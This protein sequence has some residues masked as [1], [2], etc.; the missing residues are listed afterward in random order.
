VRALLAL[1][2][3]GDVRPTAGRIAERAG[4]SLR[5]VY[6]HFDDLDD[7]FL[8]ASREQRTRVVALTRALPTTGPFEARLSAFV[9]QR[10]GV[11]DAIAPVARAAALQEPFS[12]ALAATKQAARQ[13]GRSE[14][15]RVFSIE[16]ASLDATTREHS[17]DACDALTASDAWDFLR[18]RRGLGTHAAAATLSTSLRLLLRPEATTTD[19][20]RARRWRARPPAKPAE[21]GGE[22][23]R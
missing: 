14:L 23:R 9:E 22:E 8:A 6:V 18:V 12:P 3:E 1:I 21:T 17:L 13:L 5:S 19:H 7:L 20:R 4:I 10:A 11:L 16:L 2:S 15:E